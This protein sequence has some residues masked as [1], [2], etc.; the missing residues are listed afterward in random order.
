MHKKKRLLVNAIPMNRVH[1]GISRY[2]HC[3][4]SQMEMQYSH[5]LDIWYFDGKKLSRSMP[6]GPCDMKR[7]TRLAGLF[8]KLPWPAALALRL[9]LHFRTEHRFCKLAQ[10]FD[11]YHE[12]GFFPLKVPPQVRTVFTVHDMSLFRFPEHHPRERVQFARMYWQSRC[13]SVNHFLTVS[14]FTKQELQPYLRAGKNA[15]TIT[16]LAHEPNI[17][18]PRPESK[19]QDFIRERR[20]PETYFLFVGSG[21]PRKNMHLIPR[22]LEA[23]SLDV[24]LVVAGWSGWDKSVLPGQIYPAGYVCDHELALLYSGALALVFP[25]T[26]EGFGLPVLEAMA[27]GCPVVCSYTASLPEVAGD[28]ALYVD[29][30][31]PD[32]MVKTIECIVYDRELRQT[33]REKGLEMAR[34]FS[35]VD[36]AQRTIEVLQGRTNH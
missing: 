10:Y 36:T 35:W 19:V 34:R 27:C 32:S 6:R 30:H 28:A 31:D 16:P 33:M 29:P 3:L 4:Y 22:A 1:T 17:F 21:D 13:L 11:I 9:A 23:A 15:I 7:W 5:Q 26:Y 14:R 18:Y 8:W 2:L 20:L 24:P 12:A 25:S